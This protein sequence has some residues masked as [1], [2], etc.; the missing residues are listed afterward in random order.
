MRVPNFRL[1]FI[2]GIVLCYTILL[3]V[4]YL[5][6]ST[7]LVA[8]SFVLFRQSVCVGMLPLKR[9]SEDQSARTKV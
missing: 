8:L 6:V 5:T 9:S 4:I 7:T 1:N 2:F 3:K